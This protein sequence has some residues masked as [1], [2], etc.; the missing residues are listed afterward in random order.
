MFKI[1]FSK[2]NLSFI[3]SFFL[4]FTAIFS[5]MPIQR[6]NAA[7]NT[8]IVANI[9]GDFQNQLGDSDWNISS[10]I[11]I[12][13][14]DGNGLYEFTTPVQLK[15]GSYQYKVALNHSWDDGGV[16]S[17][18]NLTLNLTSDSYVTF[19]FDYNTQSV[20]DST[21]YTPISN[22][23]L[24][25]LV[26]TI[27]SAIGAGND[28]DPG[29]STAIMTDYNFDNVYEYTAHVPK[30]NYEY[31]VTLGSTWDENYGANGVLGGS[32]IQLNVTYDTDITFYYDASTHNIWTN[33][34]PTLTGLDNNIYYDDL[35]HDT[36]DLFF[37]NPFGSIKV[38]QTVTLRIQAKNH[39]LESARISYWDD[40]N[41]T[42]TESPMT[43]IGE[44]SDGNY[45][46]WEIKLSFDHPTRIWYY[47]ILKDGTKTAYYGDNDYQL[48]GVGKATD[49]V[50]KDFELTVYDKN[51]DTPDWMKGAVMY[52]I[53][54]DRFYNG[55][56]SN[57]HVKT[58][59]RGND[60]IEFHDN[61]NELPDNPNNAGSPGYTGDGIWSNDFF[62][63]DLK[64]I[65]D[66]LDYL[67]SLGITVIYLNP[68]FESP[69]NHKYDTSDY[70]KIDEMF[71]TTQDFE[72]L[73]ED[74]HS[75]G[76]KVI[77]DG[78][79]N[80]T[81]DDSIYF[82]R[83]SKYPE[84]GT[85]EAW[86][87]GDQ[88]KSPY[89]DWYTINSDGTYEDWWG[90]DSLPVIK[91]LNGSE[92][93]VTSW[94]NFIINDKNAISKYWLN[95]DGNANG[96][97]DGWRLDV[98]TEVAHDFWTHFRDAINTV[99]PEAPMIAENWGDASS[100][101]LGDSFNSVMNYQFRNDI[102][103]FLIGKPFDDGN[104][105]HNPIDAVTLDQRLMSIYERYP[106]P[107]FYSTMNLL[108]SHDT[109]RILTVFGYNSAD[110]TENSDDA[111]NLAEQKL[112]LA[113]ILQ[114]GYPGMADIYYGDEAGVSGGKDPDDRRTFPWGNEDTSLQ[115]FF[116]NI[117]SI[118]NDN[119]VLK[120]G[121]LETLYAQGDVY[122]IGRRIINGKDAFGSHYADSAAIVA[123]NRS[124][125][126]KQITIDTTKF[127]R[128]GVIFKDLLNGNKSYSISDG[129]I[130]IDI[131]A[132]SGVM[133]ISDPG[134]DLTAPQV[135]SNITVKSGNGSVELSWSPS[136]GATGYN[137]YR[138]SVEGGLYEK[139][140]SNVS[141]TTY[142]DDSVTNGLKYVYSISAIDELGNESDK[143]IDAVAYPSYPIGWAG[144]LTQV[145]DGH[146]IGANNQT[147]DIFGE[148]WADGLTNNSGQGPHMIAQFGYKY[149]G[150]TVYNSVYGS[151]YN[152]VYGVDSSD[153]FIWVNAE[154]VGDSGNNDKYKAN[155]TPDKIG[156]WEYA[157]RFSDDQGQ[158]W[159]MTDVLSFNVVPSDDLVKPTAPVLN[160]PGIESSR[161]S[162]TWSPST[163]N[164]G[165]Y[166][167]EVYRSDGGTF[168]KIATVSNSV[169]N[170]IDT[171]V[172][173]GATYSYKVVAVDPSYNRTESNVITIKPD[174]VPI[175][176]TFNVTVP[177]YTP[178]AV[179]LA[180]TFPN[181]N[182]D[183][184][185]QQMKKVNDN[186]YSITL[187]L[188]EGTQIEYK[189]ARGSWDK[190][191][192]DE[193]G[194]ELSANRKVTIVNQGDN[195]MV[196][197]DTV[198]RW[199]DIP[200]F[201]YS[202]S[203]NMTV[204]S[205]TDTIEIKGN[206]YKGAK[207]TINGD[208]FVQDENGAFTK[209][210]HL[211]YGVNT[212]KI[213]VEPNDGIIYGNDE[214]R[215]SE[216]TKDIEIDVK[217]QGEDNGST[218]TNNG[219]SLSNG[220]VGYNGST[221]FDLGSITTSGSNVTVKID[222]GKLRDKIS[223][224]Q[225]RTI[226]I[227]LT[228]LKDAKEKVVAIPSSVLT[229]AND[230]NKDIELKFNNL[231]VL[232]SKDS[233]DMSKIGNDVTLSV[234]D[235][236][237][238]NVSNYVPL[239]NTLDISIKSDNGN[240]ALVKP[241]EV[242]INIL[243]AN[244][245]R[246]VA[247]YYYNEETNKWEYVGGKV[248][249]DAN[250]ITFSATHFSQY[251]ALEYDKT[252][253]DIKNSWAKDDIEVLA[254]RHI[255]DGMTESKY[256]PN[257]T[258]TR[259]E[260]ASM[261]LKLLNMKE[262]PYS[263]EFSDV[264]SGDWY[265]NAIEAAYKAR[266][267]EGDGKNMRPNDSITREEMTAIAMRAY[268][269]LT[270]YKEENIGNTAFN[271]DKDISDWAKNVVANAVKVGI[272]NGEPNNLFAPKGNAT[273]AEAAAIIYGLL[274]KSGNI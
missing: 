175:Q 252:F 131:P 123:I 181:I 89:G 121:D 39:D 20:T 241:V 78:V 106:L 137:I 117:T 60:P 45:E 168:S 31:K 46:Y 49:T 114:M 62:G 109:M 102:I 265:A 2:K 209:D 69:S 212:I 90:Y 266:I 6:V 47:F 120:T 93:N 61:W 71:G 165:I 178:D 44:S 107:A 92:Y 7:D 171:S 246:K 104:G 70:T 140:A 155:F 53:F 98:E 113:T 273:R 156:K 149:V 225:E 58:L 119:Q 88:T 23:K 169:Y 94:A 214:S 101:L 208:S 3:L 271:D 189:Y 158:N 160:Q 192:K 11:T 183:P 220:N 269:I 259:A 231:A 135:P 229:N 8:S 200:V 48:G 10:N 84:L 235:N 261:I 76:I 184:S 177:D 187:T 249:E 68:I 244:D 21:K 236:G 132:M 128:D 66:K 201:I 253:D 251:A 226:T 233:I 185:S 213:H 91:S 227:D 260:F 142:K 74:A 176:V 193:Y 85:Y 36:H 206:T 41:K 232:L 33:Y 124:S 136:D 30:G 18:G 55:D 125:E 188:D 240:V 238:P 202:P 25:R 122:A 133:L 257:K 72:K 96:G 73:M 223:K 224:T 215:I 100:D 256:V 159:T 194:N 51:F 222:G 274:G 172:I 56:T 126:D 173:N 199:R 245:P 258:V 37:R 108:G 248:D 130:I 147:E 28:W 82:D 204:D 179:N 57:D 80:H 219:S 24:P 161:V 174:V 162:L 52:Q 87:Q 262:E 148:V 153:D 67:K 186:T 12:M 190:V 195:K 234:K 22:D 16:P 29:T 17:Q 86:K 63:G 54:P 83:Y 134:Q 138:S 116:K 211:N 255:I 5:S 167:Y 26:G 75:K 150:G 95:P 170:Y 151:V 110:P 105:Q 129:Q 250:T 38:G 247:V 264:K 242:T 205:N 97:A 197:N 64:G 115:E 99:K 268:E 79:F 35:K 166:D 65:D 228:S 77:L 207:V 139:I 218:P 103:D 154:Y 146:I 141:G 198:Y 32:N 203:S 191:E 40:V 270:S 144:N 34:N 157:M 180:G 1:V 15:A 164:V 263:G 221:T 243:K 217:R 272:V 118:R 9:V 196:I 127:L 239:S 59:S 163:D 254:S 14:Y 4:V 237:K 112:K 13:Q 43:R 145:K 182:W 230:N 111:K 267:I 216:L 210:V 143:S 152:S 27:Q 19:W 42:R 81:S 50:N